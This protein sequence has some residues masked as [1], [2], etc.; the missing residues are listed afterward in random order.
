M[1]ER[2]EEMIEA[3]KFPE[4]AD[5]TEFKDGDDGGGYNIGFVYSVTV[6]ENGY[7]LSVESDDPI[8][9]VYQNK[10]HLIDRLKELV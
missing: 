2:S 3:L 1:G 9:E 10:D 8:L 4:F 7:I 6:V 5:E